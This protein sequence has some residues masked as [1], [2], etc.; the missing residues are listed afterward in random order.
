[1]SDRAVLTLLL[2]AHGSRRSERVNAQLTAVLGRSLPPTTTAW[3]LLT[4][5]AARRAAST[6]GRWLSRHGGRPAFALATLVRQ[7]GKC[8]THL[9][10][11]GAGE[12]GGPGTDGAGRL[13]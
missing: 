3:G 2:C 11:T 13:E 10:G 7:F 4:R 9:P 8:T 1:M 6:P 12:R 5:L